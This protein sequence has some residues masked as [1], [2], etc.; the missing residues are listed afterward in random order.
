V[1][2]VLVLSTMPLPSYRA[3]LERLEAPAAPLRSTRD[4]ILDL[5]ARTPGIAQGLYVDVPPLNL[6]HPYYYYFRKVRPWT[7]A[8]TP[9]P[10]A[11]G[12]YLEDPANQRP[13]LVWEPT[14]Q[15]YRRKAAASGSAHGHVSPPLLIDKAIVDDVFVVLPGPYGGCS[16]APSSA[17]RSGG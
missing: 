4:C 16:P 10:Q 6:P 13:V 2:A 7:R 17:Q 9:S 1:V 15:E 3:A 12:P 8:D 11:L 14:Y 5:Q